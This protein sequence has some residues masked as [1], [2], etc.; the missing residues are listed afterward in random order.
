MRSLSRKE[1]LEA[2]RRAHL[3]EAPEIGSTSG[4]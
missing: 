3:E 4:S 1:A 2:L